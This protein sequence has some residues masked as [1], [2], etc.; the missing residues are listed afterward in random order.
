MLAPSGFHFSN[1][2]QMLLS[3]GTATRLLAA[4]LLGGAVGLEREMRNKASGLRT[5]LLMCMACAFF[6]LLSAN[7]AGEGN[8]NKGQVASN[9]VQGVGF[10]GAGL[11]LHTK[12]RVLGLTSAATVFVVAAIGMACGAGLYLEAALATVIVVAALRLI[13]A[14]ETKLPY[15]QYVLL[16]EVRGRDQGSM[17]EAVLSVLDGAGIRMNVIERDSLGTM[18]RVTFAVSANKVKHGELLRE[19][20]ASDTTDRVMAFADAD[21]D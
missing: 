1:V 10:L 17:Y 13:G 7:L 11:I 8:P 3:T 2:D 20:Q 21:Q 16:Y 19:L 5:N 4:C 6:T 15:K 9:I 18:E 12:S 14:M